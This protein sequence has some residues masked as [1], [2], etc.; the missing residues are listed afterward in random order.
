MPW[1]SLSRASNVSREIFFNFLLLLSFEDVRGKL[2][3]TKKVLAAGWASGVGGGGEVEFDL[4][5]LATC[6]A[7]FES[8]GL[9]SSAG[10]AGD[11][12][13]GVYDGWICPRGDV[14]FPLPPMNAEKSNRKKE[15]M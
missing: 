10:L 7:R 11:I 9:D 8:R 4:V 15:M 5:V 13:V 3:L 6:N 12:A 1:C 14:H 2:C